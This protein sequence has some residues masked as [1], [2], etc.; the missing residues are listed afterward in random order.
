MSSSTASP[1]LPHACRPPFAQRLLG[2][3]WVRLALSIA[4]PALTGLLVAITMPRGPATSAQ[5][6]AV[7]S[8]GLAV[9]IASGFL[10]Y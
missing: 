5:A 6:L 3:R 10:V 1:L 2:K 4:A 9:G 7:M 8:I